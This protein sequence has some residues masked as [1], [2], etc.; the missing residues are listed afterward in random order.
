MSR[1][2]VASIVGIFL[3]RQPVE[4]RADRVAIELRRLLY[5]ACVSVAHELREESVV[6]SQRFQM[7]CRRVFGALVY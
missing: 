5:R 3:R 4:P 2:R 7:S 1:K 6:S